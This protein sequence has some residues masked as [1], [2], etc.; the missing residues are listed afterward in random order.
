MLRSV[1]AAG[2]FV[3]A[4]PDVIL[5]MG[6]KRVLYDTRG[7]GWGSDTHLYLRF[8]ELRDQL[9]GRLLA[10]PRILKQHRGNGGNGVWK[11]EQ[12]PGGEVRVL[13]ALRG[14]VEEDLPLE[15]FLERCRPYFEGSGLV[16]DQPFQER[17][18]EE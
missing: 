15:R 5:K 1:A 6:T 16:V 2:V 13:H 14:S 12:R 11:V 9:A 4:H 17:L 18:P 10:G 7:L 3:S 8:D